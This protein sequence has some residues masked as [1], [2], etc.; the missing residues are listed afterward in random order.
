MS[1]GAWWPISVISAFRRLRQEDGEFESSWLYSK[2]LS[3]KE[4][5]KEKRKCPTCCHF[6][7]ITLK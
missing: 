1:T 6:F 3:Q 5:K 4:K 2:T 7:T